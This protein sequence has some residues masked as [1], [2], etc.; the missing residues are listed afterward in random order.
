MQIYGFSNENHPSAHP[1]NPW[2]AILVSF[3]VYI[4]EYI[5]MENHMVEG[6]PVLELT[7]RGKC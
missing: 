1:P 4:L 3:E 5:Q 2:F 6:M 7:H